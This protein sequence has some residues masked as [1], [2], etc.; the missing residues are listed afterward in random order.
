R[1]ALAL[2]LLAGLLVRAAHLAAIARTVFPRIQLAIPGADTAAHWQWSDEIL[3]GDWLGRSTFHQFTDWMKEIA[4]LETWFRWW[5]GERIF[6]REPAYPYFL[7]ILRL[8]LGRLG[9][10]S[11]LLAVF[12]VQLLLGALRPLVLFALG[13]RLQG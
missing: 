2:I 7:A 8:A 1:I 10:G 9:A 6:Y 4:P 5:G 3:A 11:S 13:R 12:G